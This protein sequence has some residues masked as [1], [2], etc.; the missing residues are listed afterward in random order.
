MFKSKIISMLSEM[1]DDGTL[2][3]EVVPTETG[4]EKT[5]VYI[6]IDGVRY[7]VTK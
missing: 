3:V 2:K 4:I 7:D 5:M 6:Y 1:L